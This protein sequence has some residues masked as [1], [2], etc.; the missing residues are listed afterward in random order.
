MSHP[1][2]LIVVLLNRSQQIGSR[3][4]GYNCSAE[5]TKA[6]RAELEGLSLNLRFQR[7]VDAESIGMPGKDAAGFF[8]G[9]LGWNSPRDLCLANK[10]RLRSRLLS[11]D[12]CRHRLL[13]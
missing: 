13:P 3:Q 12:A 7:L 2:V 11:L 4:S 5:E 9:W 6:S 1:V 10:M 8:A